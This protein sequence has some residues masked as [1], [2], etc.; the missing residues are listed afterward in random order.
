ETAVVSSASEEKLIAKFSAATES[1]IEKTTT[2]TITLDDKEDRTIT[3]TREGTEVKLRNLKKNDVATIKRSLDDTVVDIVVTGE[4]ITGTASGITKKLNGSKATINGE[5]YDVANVAV[6]DLKTGSQ[7]VFYLDMFG[8]VAYIE[9]STGGRLDSGEKYGWLMDGYMSENGSDYVVKIMTSDGKAQEFQFANSVDYWAPGNLI[10]SV[11]KSGDDMEDIVDELLA[12]DGFPHMW[13]GTR[14]TDG[15]TADGERRYTWE[16]S[17]S[18]RLVKF[19]ANSSNQLS[20]LYCAVNVVNEAEKYYSADSDYVKDGKNITD[21]YVPSSDISRLKDSNALIFDMTNKSGSTLVGGLVGGYVITDDIIQFGVP[22]TISDYKKADSYEIKNVVSAQYNLKENG[23]SDDY[24]IADFDGTSPAAIIRF[25]DDADNPVNPADLDNVSGP[26]SMVVDDI[27]IGYDDD[28]NII[29]TINGYLGGNNVSVTTR[30]TSALAEVTG[31]NDKKYA[32]GD[33]LW[34]GTDT[35]ENSLTDYIDTGD[36]IITDGTYIL[37]YADASAIYEQLKNGETPSKYVQGSETRNYFWFD[38]ISD[39]DTDD[40]PWMRIGANVLSADV[41]LGMDIVE[42]DLSQNNVNKAIS[43]SDDLATIADVEPYRADDEEYDYGFARFA[44]KGI[45]QE[46][47][48]YRI[49]P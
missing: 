29:Y 28:D 12:N 38:R 2:K 27:D 41:K 3:V 20:R 40:T 47:I 1:D 30:K 9:G 45:L 49:K 23:L 35:S 46:V 4:S 32:V 16:K 22:K 48:I 21:P 5:R 8:R 17:Y 6:G 33:V 18:V 15:T 25:I 24:I 44:N 14:H 42:I 43:I 10:G 13:V 31:Y 39:S 11:S 36:I 37:L 19:K 7:C 26:S 34:K